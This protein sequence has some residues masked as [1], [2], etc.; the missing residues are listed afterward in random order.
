MKIARV[1][2]LA[3][4]IRFLHYKCL[5]PATSASPSTATRASAT[6]TIVGN[7]SVFVLSLQFREIREGDLRRRPTASHCTAK[8]RWVCCTSIVMPSAR[9]RSALVACRVVGA[10]VTCGRVCVRLF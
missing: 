5:T 3:L 6:T 9:S 8:N 7:R 1:S 10:V 4:L 2:Q